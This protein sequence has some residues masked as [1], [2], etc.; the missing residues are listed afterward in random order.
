MAIKT[1]RNLECGM[2]TVEFDWTC[3]KCGK[4]VTAEY[5]EDRDEYRCHH[6]RTNHIIE[7]AVSVD[8]ERVISKEDYEKE[9]TERQAARTEERK[10]DIELSSDGG[11]IWISKRIDPFATNPDTADIKVG[12]I[13]KKVGNKEDGNIY[14]IELTKKGTLCATKISQVGE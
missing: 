12:D 3:T 10:V 9:E 6:C 11:Q 1:I 7:V 4:L 14:K 13:I 8:V 2:Y 5:D